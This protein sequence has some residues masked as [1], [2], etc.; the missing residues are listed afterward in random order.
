M[1][2]LPA[3]NQT[4]NLGVPLM[5]GLQTGE[6]GYPVAATPVLPRLPDANAGGRP[7]SNLRGVSCRTPDQ[8]KCADLSN[9]SEEQSLNGYRRN[10]LEALLLSI[11]P[12]GPNASVYLRKRQI[13]AYREAE[14]IQHADTERTFR[15]V[16][17]Y[18]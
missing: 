5:Y 17:L 7:D 9:G 10:P 14:R 1:R 2:Y 16:D 8:Q 15:F 11:S 12:F 18:V 13:A 6:R 4:R 3:I